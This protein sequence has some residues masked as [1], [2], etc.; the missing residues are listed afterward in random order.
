MAQVGLPAFSL[1]LLFCLLSLSPLLCLLSLSPTLPTLSLSPTLPTL[2]L[3]YSLSL[4]WRRSDSQLSLSLPT[5]SLSP[6]NVLIFLS[7]SPVSS[8]VVASYH[9]EPALFRS[10]NS[11]QTPD[12]LRQR[13]HYIHILCRSLLKSCLPVSATSCVCV[14]V[15]VCL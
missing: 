1:S 11:T 3:S 2:S 12:S 9:S 10:G 4:K 15:C 5:L 6:S 13:S 8:F 14:C 7:R